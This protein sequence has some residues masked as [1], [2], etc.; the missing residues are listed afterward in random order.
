MRGDIIKVKDMVNYYGYDR[1]ASVFLRRKLN[2]LC[3]DYLK[4]KEIQ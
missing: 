4:G 1:Q 3:S 2:K